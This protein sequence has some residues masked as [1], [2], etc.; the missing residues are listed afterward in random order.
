MNV[1]VAEVMTIAPAYEAEAPSE[2]LPEIVMFPPLVLIVVSPP[3]VL[4]PD[5]ER[6]PAPDFWSAPEPETTPV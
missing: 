5:N 2:P 6:V 3:Y 4:A 1:L